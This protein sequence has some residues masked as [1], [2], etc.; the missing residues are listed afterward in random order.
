[1]F[2][3][4][5]LAYLLFVA[6]Q[7]L[8]QRSGNLWGWH[9]TDCKNH[10]TSGSFSQNSTIQLSDFGFRGACG[11]APSLFSRVRSAMPYIAD[12]MYRTQYGSVPPFTA[13]RPLSTNITLKKLGEIYLLNSDPA[14]AYR[15]YEINA[16][17]FAIRVGSAFIMNTCFPRHLSVLSVCEASTKSISGYG[18]QVLC[19]R[20]RQRNLSWDVFRRKTHAT[21]KLCWKLSIQGVS[22]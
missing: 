20:W 19:Y 8:A 1:M 6:H 22:G 13:E 15:R 5:I 2:P 11:E 10:D 9:E 7:I 3:K 16:N 21:A 12:I 17:T 14:P 18:Y 4:V